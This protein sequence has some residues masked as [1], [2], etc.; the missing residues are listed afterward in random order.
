MP[1]SVVA[2]NTYLGEI[3]VAARL[4]EV[5]RRAL[6]GHP[7][8]ARLLGGRQCFG[9]IVVHARLQERV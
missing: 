7:D 1:K 2:V 6:E 3:D 4:R 5:P 9:E 8:T